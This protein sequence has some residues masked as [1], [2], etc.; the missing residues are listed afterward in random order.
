[1]KVLRTVADMRRHLRAQRGSRAIVPTMGALHEGHI[2][3]F[4]AARRAS[5]HVVASL[6]V[7]PD[8]FNDPAD[9][10]A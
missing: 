3:L 6:F 7:N 5:Q 8:Q 9:L 2:A 10:A 4:R 1:M